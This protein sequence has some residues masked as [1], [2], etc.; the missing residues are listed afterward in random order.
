[1]LEI[2]NE[3]INALRHGQVDQYMSKVSFNIDKVRAM[4]R[5]ANKYVKIPY[6]PYLQWA[7]KHL[8]RKRYWEYLGIISRII[9]N[10]VDKYLKL[11]IVENIIT[12][13][14]E[15][16]INSKLLQ[17]LATETYEFNIERHNVVLNNAHISSVINH[18]WFAGSLIRNVTYAYVMFNIDDFGLRVRPMINFI[19]Y[20]STITLSHPEHGYA[21]IHVPGLRLISFRSITRSNV[22]ATIAI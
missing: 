16:D 3:V 14:I 18:P 17:T 8:R 1:M 5:I 21:K 9:D 2:E 22:D 7:S 6:G 11:P 15:A 12:K 19:V 13:I 10:F 20:N 4:L